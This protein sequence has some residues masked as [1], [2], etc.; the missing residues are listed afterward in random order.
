[1]PVAVNCSVTPTGRIESAGVID[2]EDSVAVVTVTVVLPDV[3][4]NWA[5]TVVTPA[6]LP[7][8]RPLLLTGAT[9]EAD[10]L[11]ATWAVIS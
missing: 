2:M 11:Q 3:L 9:N 5:A 8:A 4:P 1:M 6:A 7:V 10:E